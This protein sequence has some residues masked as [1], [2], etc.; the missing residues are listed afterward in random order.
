MPK[1]VSE[2]VVVIS[3]ASSGMGRAAARAFAARGAR[4]V[5]AARRQRAPRAGARQP[6]GAGCCGTACSPASSA[7]GP[8]RA[9]S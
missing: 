2:Q 9:S 1:L 6:P 5:C 7:G 3:G 8:G 4:V